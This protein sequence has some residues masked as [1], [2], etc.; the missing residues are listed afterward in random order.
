MEVDSDME[1]SSFFKRPEPALWT[2]MM[3]MGMIMWGVIRP[4]G[5][6]LPWGSVKEWVTESLCLGLIFM[7]KKGEGDL[8]S[9]SDLN[10]TIYAGTE[11]PGK[12]MGEGGTSLPDRVYKMYMATIATTRTRGWQR[13]RCTGCRHSVSDSLKA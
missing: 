10:L 4:D 5:S 12:R 3:D 13:R 11:L 1:P 2:Q 8:M 9:F 7:T 6:L